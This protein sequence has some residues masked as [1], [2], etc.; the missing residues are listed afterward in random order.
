MR[1][2]FVNFYFFFI[3]LL[4]TGN[5][6]TH[7]Q[8]VQFI[9]S[10]DSSIYNFEIQEEVNDSLSLLEQIQNHGYWNAQID[11]ISYTAPITLFGTLNQK[12]ILTEITNSN[13]LEKKLR[14]RLK[15]KETVYDVNKE[16]LNYYTKK[17]YLFTDIKWEIDQIES[18][19]WKG[20]I[21]IT[22]HEIQ[23]L[24]SVIVKSEPILKLKK[25]NRILMPKQRL[26]TPELEKF[27]DSKL[28]ALSFIELN[29]PSK[30]L[31]TDKKNLL[32]VFPKKKKVNFANGLLAFSNDKADGTSGFT[33][34]FNLHLENILKSAEVFDIKW[35]A[36]N[37]NQDFKWRNSFRYVYQSLGLENEINIYQQDSSFTKTQLALGIRLDAKPQS[38]W[39]I[40]YLFEQSAVDKPTLTRINYKKYLLLVSW[41][42]SN[43]ESNYFDISGHKIYLK[44]TVGNR[45]T[46]KD[47]E[48]EYQIQASLLKILPLS[49]TLRLVGEIQHKQII[50]NTEL[51]NNAYS[52]GGFENMKGFT[53]NRF[54]TTQYTLLTPTLRF[55]QQ[56]KYVAEL[57]YQHGFIKT[58]DEK[59]E[60]LQSF[61]LQFILPV[62]SG[63][64]NFGVSSGRVFPE[65]FNFGQ[66]LIHFGV[67]NNL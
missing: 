50:Q 40:N 58:I 19:S 26:A 34:N 39:T 31:V 41:L 63:W 3:S 36:G 32:F 1:N 59:N 23:Y 21:Q 67:K 10:S 12:Y 15:S 37:G 25:W 7:A 30:L 33:G 16:V 51:D 35:K 57:F 6:Y 2:L 45:K 62:K 18:Y 8:T 46:S 65:A 28:R 4:F 64:F 42:N 49:K 5:L 52:F 24:D 60:R 44:A 22:P 27:A 14:F 56:N 55:S 66:A 54:L 11:H 9:S 13:S 43:L 48:A 20:R 61:G 29:K 38:I 17:G 53:E 47:T